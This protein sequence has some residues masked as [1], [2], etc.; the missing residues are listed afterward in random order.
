MIIY[1]VSHLYQSFVKF[2]TDNYPDVSNIVITKNEEVYKE[3]ARKH[4]VKIMVGRSSRNEVRGSMKNIYINLRDVPRM[5]RKAWWKRAIDKALK[6]EFGIFQTM[7]YYTDISK[8]NE[9][10]KIKEM[11]I[12]SLIHI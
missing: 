2:M 12:L 8:A 1:V 10:E 6:D 4:R 7:F 9:I 3:Q 11:F 5:L